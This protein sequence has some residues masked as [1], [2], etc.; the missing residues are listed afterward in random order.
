MTEIEENLEV[1][2]TEKVKWVFFKVLFTAQYLYYLYSA[3]Y[4][5]LIFQSI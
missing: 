3:Y 2:S 1:Y 4:V 5:P